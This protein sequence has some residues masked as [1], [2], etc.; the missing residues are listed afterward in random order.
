M[1]K[2]SSFVIAVTL[3]FNSVA[4]SSCTGKISALSIG[5]TG[6]VLIKGPGGLPYTYLCNTENKYNNVETS[7]CTAIYSTLLS[8]HAQ[9]KEV[10][11]TFNPSI[12]NCSG[13]Q[14]WGA[15]TNFNWIIVN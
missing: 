10:N 2:L 12:P 6:M 1:L 5:R 3:S 9:D 11:I 8:A 4:D 14:S 13:V 7:A 15:A